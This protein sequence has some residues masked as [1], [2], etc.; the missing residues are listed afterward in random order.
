MRKR[1]PHK[2]SSRT[3]VILYVETFH[4]SFDRFSLHFCPRNGW[5]RWPLAIIQHRPPTFAVSVWQSHIYCSLPP[6]WKSDGWRRLWPSRVCHSR[7]YRP[8]GCLEEYYNCDGYN[9]VLILC[10]SVQPFYVAAVTTLKTGTWLGIWDWILL[11]WRMTTL[12]AV[13]LMFYFVV[14]ETAFSD[15]ESWES[16][17]T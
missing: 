16:I 6:R 4:A 3:L 9:A 7:K 14:L 17:E 10:T 5:S 2:L 11:G 12:Q 1:C 15:L 8:V 13:I